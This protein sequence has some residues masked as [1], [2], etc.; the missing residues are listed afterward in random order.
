MPLIDLLRTQPVRGIHI[1]GLSEHVDYW[2]HLGW[3]DPFSSAL[4][5]RRQKEYDRAA[6]A[7]VYTPQVVVNG[8][9][10]AVGSQA[11]LGR[12]GFNFNLPPGGPQIEL[13][14]SDLI[15]PSTIAATS[16]ATALIH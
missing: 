12:A 9:R 2:D 7:E 1:V 14:N 5:T 10:H 4:F 6:K 15:S 11:A 13:P 16:V 8:L 3:V